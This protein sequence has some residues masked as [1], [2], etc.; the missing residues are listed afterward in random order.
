M[1]DLKSELLT[2]F[3][4][5][6]L[7]QIVY[8]KSLGEK[9]NRNNLVTELVN[10]HN[11]GLIDVIASFKVLQNQSN[12]GVNF[13]L[14]QYV[15]EKAL[16]QLHV[17]VL[18]V[19]ECV[20]HLFK[21]ADQDMAAGTILTSFIEFCAVDCSR[22]KEAL[23]LI[24]NSTN[25]FVDLLIPTLVAGSQLD[26]EY[27]L[28]EAVQL[29]KHE[30]IEIRKRAI[31]SLGKIKYSEKSSFS[32]KALVC[33]E[34]AVS[35]EKDD[36]LLASSIR[37][38]FSLYEH[39]KSQIDR[40]TGLISN[41]LL[42]GEDH[43]LHVAADILA[44]NCNELPEPLLEILLSYLLCIK[45]ENKGTLSKIDYGLVKF[46]QQEDTNKA[47]QFLES[48]LL[49]NSNSLSLDIFQSF[50]REI[51]ESKN[52]TLS[53]LLTRWFLKG[54]RVLCEGIHTIVRHASNGNRLLSIEKSELNSF[55]PIH[56]ISFARKSIG[57]LFFYPVT[58]ASILISLIEY[59]PKDKDQLIVELRNLLF[60][61]LLINYP[62]KVGSYLNQQ[63]ENESEQVKKVVEV[64]LKD[65]ESYWSDLEST[66]EIPE[67]HPTQTQR[68]TY[69]KHTSQL[70]S[71][72][73]EKA[74]RESAFLSLISKSV[75]L[76]GKRSINY[77]Y[78]SD[79]QAKRMEIPL[80]NLSAEVE[81]ARLIKL[82]LFSLE[83]LLWV[84][85]N[86]TYH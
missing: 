47:I 43:T 75:L 17:S 23:T 32:E 21:E 30:N 3:Q 8:Q 67:L 63:R 77:V 37:S 26:I 71:E 11:E 60:D 70:V 61:P 52:N 58:A 66:G 48:L 55:D 42:R 39:N 2:A 53:R 78:S 14:T 10:L 45:A 29:T 20:L 33:L 46:F 25:Q 57:Y 51:Y 34:L 40:I 80:Q 85:K 49:A 44:S 64:V 1:A 62:G 65:L 18:P 83:L 59:I 72:S 73:P 15:L 76:Y 27:Y 38:A 68:N 13:F 54:N 35:K 36:D 31:F 74:R 81:I 9:G 12:T 22:P 6:N 41:A 79:G 82:D 7:L 69:Q 56:I 4:E 19:M 86:E 84:F 5:N 28:G 24:K 16:P 50:T